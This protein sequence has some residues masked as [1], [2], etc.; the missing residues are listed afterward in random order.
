MR[1]SLFTYIFGIFLTIKAYYLSP[2]EMN[3]VQGNY[4]CI[5][6]C[7]SSMA[8][9]H[10]LSQFDEAVKLIFEDNPS[11]LY[12]TNRNVY[13]GLIN[14][15]QNGTFQWIDGTSFDFGNYDFSTITGEFPW[16][17]VF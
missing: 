2:S 12:S 9:I 17:D 1:V 5:N 11:M 16:G 7:N 14:T 6:H 8:S 10:N 4:F 13:I 3:W 15:K